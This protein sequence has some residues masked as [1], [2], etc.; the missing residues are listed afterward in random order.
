MFS[1]FLL[2]FKLELFV[3]NVEKKKEKK[4][5]EEEKKTTSRAITDENGA[6]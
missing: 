4:K 2:L 1:V 5:K 6:N 3:R